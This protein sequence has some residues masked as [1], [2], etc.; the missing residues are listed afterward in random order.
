MGQPQFMPSSYLKYAVDFDKDGKADI[1]T[2]PAD[3]FG[4]IGNYLKQYGW[5][6]KERWGREVKLSKAARAKIDH[7]V[8]MRTGSCKAQREMTVARPIKE[9]AKFGARL[10]SG[11]KLPKSD[12]PASLVR[13]DKRFFLVYSNYDALLGYNC[14]NS[15][16]VTIGLL[17]DQIK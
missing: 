13:G 7:T 2:T 17:S 9:W 11:A 12:I 16:A 6:A 1:W 8:A 3:V 5:T 10:A 14:A 4:S 15:Y